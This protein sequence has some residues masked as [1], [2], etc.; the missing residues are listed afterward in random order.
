MSRRDLLGWG[1]P[2]GAEHDPL[3]PYN[4]PPH[5][6]VCPICGAELADAEETDWPFCSGACAAQADLGEEEDVW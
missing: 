6:D 1:Y 4:D 2:A 3:A 5:P